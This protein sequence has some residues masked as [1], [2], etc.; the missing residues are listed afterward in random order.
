MPLTLGRHVPDAWSRHDDDVVSSKHSELFKV[1]EKLTN[2]PLNKGDWEVVDLRVRGIETYQC[3][4]SCNSLQWLYVV[5]H[6][7]T[8]TKV[9]IGSECIRQLGL[10]SSLNSVI[11]GNRCIGNNLIPD[12]RTKDAKNGRC[13]DSTCVCKLCRLCLSEVCECKK[14][15]RCNESA[16]SLR[17]FLCTKCFHECFMEC[18]DGCGSY[19]QRG[20]RR[21][22]CKDC[23]IKKMNERAN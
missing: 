5:R 1:L 19:V 8:D 12:M 17:R 6:V 2:S 10:S 13:P 20:K 14:C 9:T 11:R 16:E 18:V 21:P 22:R 23:Y 3:L 15:S 7:P 4:C